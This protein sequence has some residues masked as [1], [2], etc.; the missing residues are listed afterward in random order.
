MC[1]AY[2]RSIINGK[3]LYIHSQRE[4]MDETHTHVATTI[5]SLIEVGCNKF[6]HEPMDKMKQILKIVTQIVIC[7]MI[8]V[9]IPCVTVMFVTCYFTFTFM[10]EKFNTYKSL[11][12]ILKSVTGNEKSN[13]MNYGYWD[14]PNMTL[15][16]ANRRL[17]KVIFSRGDLKSADRILDIGCGY[18][19]QDFYWAH[20]T[21]ARIEG[22]DI[23]ETSIRAA[24][25]ESRCAEKNGDTRRNIKFETG[26]ACM[27]DRKN[28]TYDR[29]VSLES[30]FHYIPRESFFQEAYRVLKKGGKLVM[31]D[32]L[33]NDT[34]SVNIFNTINRDAFSE[35]F[36]IPTVNKIGV[37]EY[38]KQLEDIGFNVKVEDISDKT[39]KPYYKYFFENVTC[40]DDFGLHYSIFNILRYASQ[41]YINTLCG[42]TNGF[43]YVITV[44]EKRDD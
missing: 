22:I 14:K 17:C 42:G 27:I 28:A 3:G 9:V 29:V 33:Y 16:E 13:F 38:T 12:R 2:I 7:I 4:T 21:R 30:A 10:N 44:C 39:F 31:A 24:Q 11:I 37:R 40:P 43:T 6:I 34:S 8:I 32:I 19:S 1:S 5:R 20:K 26:N 25:A 23:D 35:M 18:G 36:A 15:E 41:T